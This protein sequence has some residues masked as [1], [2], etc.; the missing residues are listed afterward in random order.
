MRARSRR[1]SAYCSLSAASMS[2]MRSGS[3]VPSSSVGGVLGR[4]PNPTFPSGRPAA[5]PRPVRP[6]PAL[7]FRALMA[8]ATTGGRVHPL[9]VGSRR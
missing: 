2:S 1:H 3:N 5:R 8:W 4:S 7:G 6:R 9:V